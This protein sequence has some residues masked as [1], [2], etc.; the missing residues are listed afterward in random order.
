MVGVLNRFNIEG[1]RLYPTIM[2]E[3]GPTLYVFALQVKC[4]SAFATGVGTSF[5]SCEGQGPL[6]TEVRIEEQDLTKYRLFQGAD[7][8]LQDVVRN[9]RTNVFYALEYVIIQTTFDSAV[10]VGSPRNYLAHLTLGNANCAFES[11]GFPSS[12]YIQT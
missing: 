3:V 5:Y 2:T 8:V 7:S 12:S 4:A 6:H 11:Q 1:T 10:Y 9:E